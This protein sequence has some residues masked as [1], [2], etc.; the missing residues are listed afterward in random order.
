MVAARPLCP[1]ARAARGAAASSLRTRAV[2]RRARFRR[3]RDA[4]AA[5]QPRA[6]AASPR[7]RH[8]VCA[9]RARA[10]A[11]AL[12]PHLARI[13]DEE[14]AGAGMP[15]I[16]QLA[17]VFRNG[18]RGAHPSARIHDARMVSRRRRLSRSDD[19]CEALLRACAPA[20]GAAA[21]AGRAQPPIR[22]AV[23]TSQRRRGVPRAIA[24]SICWR[25]RPTRRGPTLALLAEAARRSA[26]R[27]MPA[28][29]GRIFF[30]H[31]PRPDR[32]ASRHRRADH[33]LRLSDLDGGARAAAS[34]TIRASPSGSS[35][36]SAASSSP[37]PS[38]S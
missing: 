28:M 3:G 33:P 12:S 4:G 32:A 27:R 21:F 11:A 38:A 7:L 23:R 13:R 8:R 15:R 37:T 31:L 6:R 34:P 17:H 24:A 18:E 35:S 22:R 14:A 19:D 30:P 10:D 25:P 2:L 20:A 26:S 29:I 5:G 16:F 36:M 9:S 1:A